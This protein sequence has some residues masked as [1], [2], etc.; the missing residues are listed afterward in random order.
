MSRNYYCKD[1]K[2]YSFDYDKQVWIIDGKYQGCGH[3]PEMQCNCYGRLH[4]GEQ[5]II[6]EACQ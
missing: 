6:T 4:A 2:K 1:K 5:A 3:K